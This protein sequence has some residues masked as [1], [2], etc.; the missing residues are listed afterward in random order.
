[1]KSQPSSRFSSEPTPTK[2]ICASMTRAPGTLFSTVWT[3]AVASVA[4]TSF[5]TR[6]F[7][8]DF[9]SVYVTV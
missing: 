7:R 8:G 4:K 9:G 6:R 3:T 1:M 2:V 5:K